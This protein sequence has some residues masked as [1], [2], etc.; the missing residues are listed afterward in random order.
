[1][2]ENIDRNDFL[3]K[4]F[5]NQD[6]G[7]IFFGQISFDVGGRVTLGLHIKNKPVV[8]VKKWGVWGVDY[9]VIVVEVL[10]KTNGEIILNNQFDFDFE[11]VLINT[12]KDGF[13]I[14]QEGP[15]FFLQIPVKYLVFQ[16]CS[17]YKNSFDD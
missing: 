1:M 9:N 12:E 2:I 8:E 11:K 17:I 15:G 7:A 5:P 6:F 14:K 3:R 16:G 4:L 10:G 13:L